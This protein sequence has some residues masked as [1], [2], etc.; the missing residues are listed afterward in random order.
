MQIRQRRG[1]NGRPYEIELETIFPDIGAQDR[2]LYEEFEP[3]DEAGE[4]K[5]DDSE[6][7]GMP[8]DES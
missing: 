1:G 7:A 5:G 8:E 2:S 4:V 3:L 6:K